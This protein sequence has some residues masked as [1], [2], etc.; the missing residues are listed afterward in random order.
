VVVVVGAV[1]VVVACVVVVVG[2]VVVVVACVV[3][4]V[5]PVVVVVGAVVVVVGCVVVVVAPVVVVVAP[6]VVVVAPVVVVV[7]PVVVVEPVVV[8]ADWIV[9]VSNGVGVAG[10][11]VVPS[12]DGVP[13]WHVS[14]TVMTPPASVAF[15]T[16]CVC[17]N[18][19]VPD[20]PAVHIV[21]GSASVA[22]NALALSSPLVLLAGV[23]SVMVTVAVVAGS[24]MVCDPCVVF[25]AEIVTVP[26]TGMLFE[27]TDSRPR[28]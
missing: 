12:A 27:P 28:R 4:V 10:V 26:D 2:A 9:T 8:V 13:G 23:G 15:T 1:V 3:V 11:N 19:I 18:E 5:A 22:V 25:D 6:V 24:V 16:S 17:E 7:A 14:V 21:F 20:D